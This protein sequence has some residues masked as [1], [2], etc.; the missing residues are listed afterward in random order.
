MKKRYLSVCKYRAKK[1]QAAR[2]HPYNSTFNVNPTKFIAA[3]NT[4]RTTD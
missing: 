1:S 3:R 2:P 4:S